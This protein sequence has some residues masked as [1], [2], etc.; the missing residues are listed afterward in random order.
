MKG[1]WGGRWN[2]LG[3]NSLFL[4]RPAPWEPRCSHLQSGY[5]TLL[6]EDLPMGTR[7]SS[8]QHLCVS[9]VKSPAI[10]LCVCAPGTRV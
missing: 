8:Y 7:G 1:S 9:S 3:I 10:L 5:T 6:L 4:A 2:G